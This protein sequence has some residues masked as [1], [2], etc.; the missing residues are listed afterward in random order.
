[1]YWFLRLRWNTEVWHQKTFVS[2]KLSECFQFWGMSDVWVHY[3]YEFPT[4]VDTTNLNRYV[5]TYLCKYVRTY[6]C[7]YV[8]MLGTYPCKYVHNEHTYLRICTYIHGYICT[9]VFTYLRTYLHT[10]L[11]T[12]V[13]LCTVLSREKL[14]KTWIILLLCRT[15]L[16]E[17]EL[18]PE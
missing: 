10:Y 16:R 17:W 1:M 15:P 8:Q 3:F 7:T 12:Y 11:R 13:L 9:Y 14:F 5:C 18:I 6:L 2:R 4:Y